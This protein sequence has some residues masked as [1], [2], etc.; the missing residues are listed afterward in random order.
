MKY[1]IIAG[2]ASGD[3][4]GAGL[5]RQLQHFDSSALFVGLGGDKM[6]AMG[7]QMVQDY[8]NMAFMGI[9]AV[10]RNLG[11]VNENFRLA[12][13]AL[14]EQQPDTLILIDYPS[15][16]LRIA[17]Y[18]K[19]HLPQ[20]RIF[21]YIPPKIW[22]WKRWR[23]HKIARL[24]DLVLGIF[25]F[26]P[27]F[28]AGYGYQAQYVGNP[29]MDSVRAYRADHLQTAE[30]EKVIAV[31]PGSRRQ[32]IAKCLPTML[33]AARQE[34]GYRIVVAGAP[35]IEPSFY[36]RFVQGE[37][38]VFGETYSLLSRASVAI[39]NSGT[40]T[41]E[42]ALLG[43]PQVAVYHIACGHF[44]WKIRRLVF[45]IPFFTLVNILGNQEVI[46]ECIGP[47][48]TTTNVS[49][50]THRLLSDAPYRENMLHEYEQ[51]RM[52]L[53]TTPAAST[54]A[55]QIVEYM[56]KNASEEHGD[57]IKKS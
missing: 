31:L 39:V 27:A 41:L 1:F 42:A 37:E 57:R 28:Y 51:I 23:V 12:E 34:P 7:C 13:A 33:D 16:N 30:R 36:D 44:L 6:H 35:G 52:M 46:K 19:K 18:C 4:H 45:S 55:K 9:S 40:A 38:L 17:A 20:T 24:S 10:L 43:C 3:L 8:R 54:A 29:T 5:M 32:E 26:E 56:Q 49:H 14:M 11:K 47:L 48:F 22:A 25:P 2:E 53:G 50:E 15:F 21:Y